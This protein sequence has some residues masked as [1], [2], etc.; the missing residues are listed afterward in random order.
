MDISKSTEDELAEI[1]NRKIGFVFQSFN[2][3]P[4]L[5]AFENVE[6]PMIYAGISV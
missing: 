3:L 5:S 1:R 2:L 6:L 4:K